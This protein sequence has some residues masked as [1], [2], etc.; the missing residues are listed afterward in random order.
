[1]WSNGSRFRVR[2]GA[3]YFCYQ[4]AAA[5]PVA[6]RLHPGAFATRG[7]AAP[8]ALGKGSAHAPLP[9]PIAMA[10]AAGTA[11]PS[12]AKAPR[13]DQQTTRAAP[14]VRPSVSPAGQPAT[15]SSPAA[16]ARLAGGGYAGTLLLSDT[17]SRLTSW[18]KTST[19]C[20]EQSWAVA[21]GYITTAVTPDVSAVRREIG[22]P[23]V[24]SDS[25]AATVAVKYLRVWS[26][27]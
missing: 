16:P 5:A 27:R 23:P 10:T 26:Y 7:L 12:A 13:A 6:A 14:T 1:M 3:V 18:D 4:G 19:A 20:P 21:D 15:G 11:A 24:N 2:A 8:P 9:S 22:G 17:G 25:S